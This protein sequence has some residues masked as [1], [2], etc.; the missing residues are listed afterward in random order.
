MSTSIWSS[1]CIA[2]TCLPSIAAGSTTHAFR[3]V[4]WPHLS[5]RIVAPLW[6]SF[7]WLAPVGGLA[8]AQSVGL[9]A[10]FEDVGVEGDAVDDRG[11]QAGVGEDGAPF[12]EGQVGGDSDRGAFFAF[13]DDLEQ[14]FGSARVDVD[15]AE[16]VEAE[17][18][19]SSVAGDDAGQDAFVGGFDEFVDQLGGSDVADA[20]ALFAGGQAQPD[21]QMALMPTSA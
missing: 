4:S 2:A 3:Q 19:E 10:G 18:V 8:G 9:G 16:L 13:G 11:D 12:A 5:S 20:A 15:V 1:C 7:A 17:Q 21:E 6:T 14:Q